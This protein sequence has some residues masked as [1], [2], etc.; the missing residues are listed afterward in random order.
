MPPLPSGTP[1]HPTRLLGENYQSC[2]K[3]T[4][5]FGGYALG[6]IIDLKGSKNVDVEC[7]ELTDHGQCTRMGAGHPASEGCRSDYPLSDYAGSGIVTDES[8]AGVVLKNL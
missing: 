3:K 4:Q 6:A 2:N 8:T 5:L 7:L 1:G